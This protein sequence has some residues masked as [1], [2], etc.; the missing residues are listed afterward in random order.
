MPGWP[1]LTGWI[2]A[3]LIPDGWMVESF[4]CSLFHCL[5]ANVGS[6]QSMCANRSAGA[7]QRREELARWRQLFVRSLC[8]TIPVFLTAMVLPM[9]PFF[10]AALRK[11]LLGFPLDEIIKWAFT[12]PIQFVIG[13]R[14]HR[15]AWAALRSGRHAS[16][17]SLDR[18]ELFGAAFQFRAN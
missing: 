5:R 13:A 2:P 14:F 7:N 4:H 15:G 16:L 9:L 17:A 12:T 11:Q 8:L 3:P 6:R 18:H 10:K 1:T